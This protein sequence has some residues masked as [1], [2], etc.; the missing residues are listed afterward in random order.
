MG[1]G[2]TLVSSGEESAFELKRMLKASGL[3]ADEDHRGETEFTSVTGR[4]TLSAF[5]LLVLAG[6]SA[7]RHGGSTLTSIETA[8]KSCR[9]C[10]P[11]GESSILTAWTRMPRS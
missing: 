6:G 9:C 10:C 3:R 7:P 11:S 5:C 1:P 8:R 2:V 4:R